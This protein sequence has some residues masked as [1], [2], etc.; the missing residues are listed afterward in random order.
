MQF[1][2]IPADAVSPNPITA[3][4]DILAR[5]VIKAP[6][7]IPNT[8]APPHHFVLAAE[9]ESAAITVRLFVESEK[10]PEPFLNG[11]PANADRVWRFVEQLDGAAGEAVFSQV[12]VAPGNYYAQITGGAGAGNVALIGVI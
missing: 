3:A 12:P 6:L 10:E 11:T 4:A 5:N 7:S 8:N 9:D 1:S 2:R